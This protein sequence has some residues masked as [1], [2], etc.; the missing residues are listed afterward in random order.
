M[1]LEVIN[2]EVF[3]SLPYTIVFENVKTDRCYALLKYNQHTFK[4]S[5]ASDLLKPSIIAVQPG[6]CAVGIDEHFAI[7]DFNSNQIIVNIELSFPFH[8]A[9]VVSNSII[10]AS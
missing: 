6:V 10:V 9:R 3:Y 7:V 4:L 1:M 5:W 8:E 2:K